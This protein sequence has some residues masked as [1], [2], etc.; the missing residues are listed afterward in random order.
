M[1]MMGI[2][3]VVE[4]KIEVLTTAFP[5]QCRLSAHVHCFIV[6]TD[7]FYWRLYVYILSRISI[8]Q[9]SFEL[10]VVRLVR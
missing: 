3:I 5:S 8:I 6:S 2:N 10:Y 1:G 7:H 9:L 4:I